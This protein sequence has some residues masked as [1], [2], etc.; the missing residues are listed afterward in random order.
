MEKR[1]NN[2][3][4]ILF[5]DIE[6]SPIF[7]AVW[8][9]WDNNLSLDMIKDDWYILSY[10][11][12][13]AGENKTILYND[14]RHTL[15]DDYDLLTELWTLLNTADVIIGHNLDKF[16]IKKIN[17]RFILNGFT[18]P[19]PYVTIDTLK[20]A[21]KTFNFT[22]NKLEYLTDKL[23]EDKKLKHGK[24]PGYTLW[25]E[26]L[27]G[28][29]EAWQEMKEYNIMDVISLEELYNVLKPWH[30][31]HPVIYTPEDSDEYVCPKCGGK[32][33]Q[34]RGMYATKAGIKYQRYQCQECFGWSK[35]R[36]QEKTDRSVRESMPTSV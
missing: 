3:P 20:M 8:K 17:A 22:S 1:M 21:K 9:M 14:C 15:E 23:C 4:N 12:K 13:W 36:F 2:Q 11:A 31:N 35:S 29:E 26:C 18:P 33:L 7:G 5:I 24:F 30:P 32:H 6:T 19:S 25:R 28:N 34:K 16:D 10:C 27:K